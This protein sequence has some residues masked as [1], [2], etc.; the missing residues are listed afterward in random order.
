MSSHPLTLEILT[1]NSSQLILWR[2]GS[3]KDLFP[4]L[5]LYAEKHL[6]NGF[7]WEYYPTNDI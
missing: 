6:W 5:A 2:K 7:K 3:T 1:L 4:I